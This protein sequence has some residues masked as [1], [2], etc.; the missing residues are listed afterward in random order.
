ML[1]GTKLFIDG[2]ISKTGL[3]LRAP[4]RGKGLEIGKNILLTQARF[5]IK[6]ADK[7][8]ITIVGIIGI[9]DPSLIFEGFYPNIFFLFKNEHFIV[10][11]IRIFNKTYC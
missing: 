1:L 5:L 10:K 4:Y 11:A 8:E 2:D 3:I 9:K 6:V 7:S